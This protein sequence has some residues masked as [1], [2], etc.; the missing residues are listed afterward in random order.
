MK[1]LFHGN[2][3]PATL[4]TRRGAEIGQKPDPV[5]QASPEIFERIGGDSDRR[6]PD[7]LF[8]S[9][10]DRNLPPFL[11]PVRP[12]ESSISVGLKERHPAMIHFLSAVHFQLSTT[13]MKRRSFLSLSA[14]SFVPVSC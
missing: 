3:G 9:G 6:C 7:A 11:L 12:E 14:L 1:V 4:P 2:N 5:K 10:P 13:R 8:I